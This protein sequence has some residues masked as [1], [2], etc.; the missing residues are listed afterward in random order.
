MIKKLWQKFDC[1][2]SLNFANDPSFIEIFKTVRSRL[3]K[4][5]RSILKNARRFQVRL[6]LT[7]AISKMTDWGFFAFKLQSAVM[8]CQIAAFK[9]N[10]HC[11]LHIEK[12]K[13]ISSNKKEKEKKEHSGSRPLNLCAHSAR[14]LGLIL[15]PETDYFT[16]RKLTWV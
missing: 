4:L 15:P 13:N 10:P 9:F 11:H 12:N 7:L 1:S 16:A 2:F 14:A 8:R 6:T 5:I 3:L